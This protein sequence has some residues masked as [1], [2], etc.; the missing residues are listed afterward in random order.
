VW[1]WVQDFNSLLMTAEARDDG[2]SDPA[3]FCGG[4]SFASRDAADYPTFLRYAFRGSLRASYT[5]ANL[6]F[7]CSRR[8]E[9]K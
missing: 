9:A 2:S 4:G 5:T 3:L 8:E 7:R 6:G 1:E